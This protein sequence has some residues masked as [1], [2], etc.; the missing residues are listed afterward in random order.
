MPN[1]NAMLYANN[2]TI[3]WSMTSEIRRIFNVNSILISVLTESIQIVPIPRADDL[4]TSQ[5][6]TQFHWVAATW[7][8][9]QTHD[10][11]TT[12]KTKTGSS[13]VSNWSRRRLALRFSEVRVYDWLWTCAIWMRM[14]LFELFLLLSVDPVFLRRGKE[15]PFLQFTL[16][17][18]RRRLANRTWR[19]KVGLLTEFG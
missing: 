18:T 4:M 11:T 12:L 15:V 17:L 19:M 6:S 10:Y 7:N 16:L 8:A 3:I 13:W 9:N 1:Y 5:Q 2:R 14:R